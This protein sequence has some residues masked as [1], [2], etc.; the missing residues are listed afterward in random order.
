[1][2]EDEFGPITDQEVYETICT[3]EV[4]EIYPDDTPYPSVLIFGMTTSNRP[5]HAVCAY[6]S[7][8]GRAVIVTVYQPDPDLWEDYRRRK[9]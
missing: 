9:K 8:D 5:L 4:I 1:M 3:G 2:R 6:D 7:Q